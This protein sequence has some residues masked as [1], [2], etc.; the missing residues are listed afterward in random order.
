MF[1]VLLT[2]QSG[3]L[4]SLPSFRKLRLAITVSNTAARSPKLAS[5]SSPFSGHK[6]CRVVRLA[7]VSIASDAKVIRRFRSRWRNQETSGKKW[8]DHESVRQTR[9]R[10]SNLGFER[11]SRFSRVQ[12]Q[13]LLDT[14][15]RRKVGWMLDESER[16][17][18]VLSSQGKGADG[19]RLQRQRRFAKS[20]IQ[21]AARKGARWNSS[22]V[23]R[24]SNGNA[25][26]TDIDSTRWR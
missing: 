1:K 12:P 10:T 6:R 20:S 14:R 24:S 21:W 3:S 5:L 13:T 16:E 8:K 7:A 25:K 9:P 15:P 26:G 17:I 4:V 23:N 18:S 19:K 22:L 2:M 11:D